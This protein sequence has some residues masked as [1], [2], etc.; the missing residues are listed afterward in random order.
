MPMPPAAYRLKNANIENSSSITV[1]CF[2]KCFLFLDAFVLNTFTLGVIS[3]N[4]YFI[5]TPDSQNEYRSNPSFFF[6][7]TVIL[8]KHLREIALEKVIFNWPIFC[9]KVFYDNN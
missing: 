2:M 5:V 4:T 1:T 9:L 6:A 3:V 7:L 8:G